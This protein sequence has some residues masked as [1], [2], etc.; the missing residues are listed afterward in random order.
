MYKQCATCDHADKP[1]KRC[2]CSV[3]VK[4]ELKDAERMKFNGNGFQYCDAFKL[5]QGVRK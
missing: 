1:T 5:R 2:A 4:H 3:N